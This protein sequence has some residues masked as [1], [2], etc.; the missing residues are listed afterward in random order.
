MDYHDK[1]KNELIKQIEYMTQRMTELETKHK[2]AE[3]AVSKAYL[4]LEKGLSNAPDGVFLI[5][6]QGIFIYV[7]PT[8]LKM[9][10]YEEKDV[11]G[12]TI[13]EIVPKI[14]PPGSA[15]IIQ[16][17]AKKRLETNEP[18]IGA[19]VEL[20]N[21]KGGTRLVTYSASEI[22][23]EQGDVIGEVVFLRDITECKRVEE[24]LRESEKKYRTLYESNLD[25]IIF[26][27]T[28]GNIM[29]ANDSLSNMLGFTKAEIRQ[30][31]YQALTPPEWTESDQAQ[32]EQISVQGYI[33][34][35]E[36]EYFRKDGTRV[37]IELSAWAIKNEIGKSIGIWG[38]VRDITE[39][40]QMEEELILKDLVFESSVAA[41]STADINGDINHCNLAFLKI[42]GYD[43]KE[44]V[45]G[46]PIAD[47]FMNKEETEPIL[48]SVNTTGQWQGE[49]LAKKKDGST[50]ISRG[51]A[52]VVKNETGK[53][54]GYQSA[55]L[56]ITDQIQAEEELK[57][58]LEDLKCSNNELEQFAYV[59]SHDLQEPLRMVASYTQLLEQRYKDKLDNDAKDFINFAVDG[60]NRMQRLINDLLIYSRLSTRNEPL[61]ITDCHSALGQALANLNKVLQESHALVTNDDLPSIW[62]DETQFV[63]LFQNLIA[64]AIKF[65]DDGRPRIHISTEEKDSE[66]VF[67]IRD[68]GLGIEPEFKDRIF[69]IF[70]RLHSRDKYPGTGIGLA[71]CKKIV[72]R[73]GGK[74][75]FDSVPGKGSTFLFTIPKK[76]EIS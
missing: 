7:N 65:K 19:E 56:D 69:I 53:M 44:E 57:K 40:K 27:D 43:K 2:K 13:Q 49:F 1:T 16:E 59:A 4:Y 64:N 20:L 10:G 36:K 38:I 55:N 60:A 54:I 71:I 17:R 5:D 72:E 68:N 46:R 29:D 66:W 48:Q 8:F 51:Y 28:D 45:L 6:K 23:D 61:K 62:A 31:S 75:W 12:K 39:R 33:K 30:L 18:I 15:K 63:L 47:F 52:T 32:V 76:G 26:T 25:G 70:Q 73:H 35:Q 34:S 14:V 41:N 50:F 22:R 11:V 67:S 42:W 24:V 9:I 58:T 21:K 3:E 74:I 37:P